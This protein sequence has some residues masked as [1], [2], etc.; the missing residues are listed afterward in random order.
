MTWEPRFIANIESKR[1]NEVYQIKKMQTYR[2]AVNF[3]NNGTPLVMIAIVFMF[4]YLTGH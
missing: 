2:I 4:Y 3:I 1:A